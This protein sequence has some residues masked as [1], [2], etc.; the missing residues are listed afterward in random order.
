MILKWI[1]AVFI[2][3]A[4]LTFGLLIVYFHK[5]EIKSLKGLIYAIDFMECELQYRIPP[6]PELCRRTADKCIPDLKKVFLNLSYELEEQI[7]PDVKI[8]MNSVLSKA[9]DI[10]NETRRCLTILGHSMGKFDLN[11]QLKALENVRKECEGKLKK[12]SGC[13]DERLRSYQTLGICA[14]IALI[15]LLM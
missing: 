13:S 6:L 4:C 14:G 12:I 7:V 15:I 2:I 8:C 11:G 10:P 3:V 9:T 1:G 5:K